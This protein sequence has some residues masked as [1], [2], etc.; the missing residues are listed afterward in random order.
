M[1]SRLTIGLAISCLALFTMHTASAE[2]VLTKDGIQ[3]IQISPDGDNVAIHSRQQ[4]GDDVIIVAFENLQVT[5]RHSVTAPMR[6]ASIA[7]LNSGDL[8][9]E[10][11]RDIDYSYVPQPTGESSVLNSAGDVRQ[12]VEED[13]NAAISTAG[14]SSGESM[15]R[16]SANQSG[17][18]IVARASYPNRHAEYFL[19]DSDANSKRRLIESNTGLYS[20][21]GR[22]P[23]SYSVSPFSA[24]TTGSAPASGYVS[25]PHADEA[26]D[27]PTVVLLRDR[28]NDDGV[29][30]YDSENNF[31]NRHKL[32]VL[33]VN[34]DGK[35]STIEQVGGAIDWAFEQGHTQRKK[36]C[37]IGRGDTG[38]A[39]I[40]AGLG[41]DGVRC[42]V[43]IG[44][45]PGGAQ[46]LAD[47]IEKS[48]PENRSAHV[49]MIS[50]AD[51][52]QNYIDELT[53]MQEL[54]RDKRVRSDLLL[55][56]GEKREFSNRNNEVH[57][58]AAT[59][60]LVLDRIGHRTTLAILPMTLEQSEAMTEIFNG[61]T[62]YLRE[63]P[64]ND[65]IAWLDR[66]GSQVQA[67]LSDEQWSLYQ[68]MLKQM[69]IDEKRSLS[70][71]AFRIYQRGDPSFRIYN[72]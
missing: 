14:D 39:A 47:S 38:S 59:S 46:Q 60:S 5:A 28:V 64:L 45:S 7:W 37:I 1:M 30:Q 31:F 51:E 57:A 72:D 25:V 71:P 33:I 13:V 70:R 6:L 53:G 2:S 58:L 9:I 52:S 19:L 4:S 22:T 49:L 15:T 42:A 27:Y 17:S 29:G 56:P 63:F 55:V 44:G 10:M 20:V 24:A 43:S 61:F 50:G 16:I 41:I 54:L 65:A 62:R 12:R 26:T 21:G 69:A 23:E 32:A 3:S 67:L 34:L 11:A 68:K 8:V 66:R 36:V 18:R 40:V 35:Q 48:G